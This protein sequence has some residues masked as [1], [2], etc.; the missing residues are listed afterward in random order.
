M[1]FEI[2]LICAITSGNYFESS[3][4]E[5]SVLR[6]TGDASVEQHH[7]DVKIISFQIQESKEFTIEPGVNLGQLI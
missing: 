6:N 3:E 5:I 7:G 1:Y 2:A 4:D